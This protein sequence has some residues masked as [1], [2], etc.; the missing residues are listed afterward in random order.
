[1]GELKR[2]LGGDAPHD[3]S[4]DLV[5]RQDFFSQ[6]GARDKAGHS[7]DDAACLVLDDHGGAGRA[8]RFAP[9]QS[10]LSHAGQNHAQGICAVNAR[11]PIGKAHPPTAGKNFP[12]ALG[13]C[14]ERMRCSS[15]C[16]TI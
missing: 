7:P 2:G 9:F 6:S 11:R 14:P 5:E 4:A 13:A 10:V 12:E 16:T 3:F 8:K 1:M 15:S